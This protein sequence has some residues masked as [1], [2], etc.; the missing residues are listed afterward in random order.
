MRDTGVRGCF[1]HI[2]CSTPSV[3]TKAR[4][5]S[6]LVERYIAV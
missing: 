2:Y 4:E 6:L 3:Y 5:G 1:T